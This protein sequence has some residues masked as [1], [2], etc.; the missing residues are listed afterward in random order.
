MSALVELELLGTLAWA[1]IGIDVAIAPS[2]QCLGSNRRLVEV[3]RDGDG[4]VV[5]DLTECEDGQAIRERIFAKFLI[6]NGLYSNFA[7]YPTEL[8]GIPIG[9]RLSDSQLLLYH[10]FAGEVP[11]RFFVRHVGL[12]QPLDNVRGYPRQEDINRVPNGL[13]N[14]EVWKHDTGIN[15]NNTPIT[16]HSGMPIAEILTHLHDHGCH[17]LTGQLGQYEISDYPMSVGG[18]GEIYLAKLRCGSRVG[19][20]CIRLVIDSTDDGRNKLKR[21]AHELYVW[22]KCR[23]PNILRLIGVTEHRGQIAMVSPWMK[24]GDL[25]GFLAR[26][27]KPEMNR[28]LLCTQIADG[29]AYLHRM[30]IVHGDLKG[31]NILVSDDSTPK[32]I[33]FGGAGLKKYTLQFSTSTSRSGLSIRWTA[34]EIIEDKTGNT[35]E[36]DVY[37]LAM[38]ILEVMTGE[39]P[40][41]SIRNDAAVIRRVVMSSHPDRPEECIPTRSAHGNTLWNLLTRC[42]V[43][44]PLERP[45][46]VMVHDVMKSITPEGLR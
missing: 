45:E 36:A 26:K 17:N 2:P 7:I 39:P 46:A 44:N 24:N 40:Y 9:D 14:R 33:D 29:V 18:F 31:A 32:I 38:T 15:T 34:P 23:H 28:C 6:P 19:L 43:Y 12:K 22:S 1:A 25:S 5:I 20:K 3:T 41:A 13:G 4:Y 16:I 8:G 27:P 11:L 42:G 21:A 35:A 30:G 37:S 10:R